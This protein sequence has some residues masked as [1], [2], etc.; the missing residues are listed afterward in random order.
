M[1]FLLTPCI[2]NIDSLSYICTLLMVIYVGM[3]TIDENRP[4]HMTALYIMRAKEVT[5]SAT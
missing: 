4:G 3:Q 1:A 5:Q 2:V